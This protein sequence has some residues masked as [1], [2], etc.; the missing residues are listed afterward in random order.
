M[1]IS[2]RN[3]D[4]MPVQQGGTAGALPDLESTS[5]MPTAP[6]IRR[7]AQ[8]MHSANSAVPFGGMTAG[9]IL[10]DTSTADSHEDNLMHAMALQQGM[11]AKMS[12]AGP[13]MRQPLRRDFQQQQQQQL[14]PP[15]LAAS[16]LALPDDDNDDSDLD[17]LPRG[18]KRAGRRKIRIEYI[19]DKSRRHITFS[20]RKA[21]IMKK[22]HFSV[23]TCANLAG[24][25]AVD[26]DRHPS[27]AP[28]SLRD[29]PR[30]HIRH[31]Q[32]AAAHH[33]TRGEEPHPSVSKCA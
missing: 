29:G 33:E 25:R 21:G 30:V 19:E 5:A 8:E 32:A 2:N 26:L 6:N 27:P 1:T 23:E 7:T 16:I 10:P 20:K 28:C 18:E 31:A 17:D 22:A 11:G 4:G 24:V 9:H 14:P 15:P 13:T 12:A 3:A